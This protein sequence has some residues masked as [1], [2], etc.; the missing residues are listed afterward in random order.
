MYDTGKLLYSDDGKGHS[1]I[2]W[3]LISAILGLI[4]NV[5]IFR[6]RWNQ[7]SIRQEFY[8]LWNELPGPRPLPP[9]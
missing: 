4:S 9:L 2:K 6:E 8:F 3:I 1:S 7:W 5:L